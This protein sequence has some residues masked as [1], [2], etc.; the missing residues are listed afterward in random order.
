MA[1][2][3]AAGD[4][5]LISHGCARLRAGRARPYT[6]ELDLIWVKT[7]GTTVIRRYPFGRC[8]RRSCRRCRRTLALARVDRVLVVPGV[9]AFPTSHGGYWVA[10]HSDDIYGYQPWGKR[11]SK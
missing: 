7:C 5:A 8:A 2:K 1:L 3:L 11:M 9:R 4:F 6:V 10:F